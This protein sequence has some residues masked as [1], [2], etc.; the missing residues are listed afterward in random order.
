VKTSK[1]AALLPTDKAWE[2]QQRFVQQLADDVARGTNGPVGSTDL[3]VPIDEPTRQ[4]DVIHDGALVGADGLYPSTMD[5]GA[6]PPVLP[7][8]GRAVVENVVLIN[9]IMTDLAIHRADMQALANTGA[10]VTGVRNATAG[11]ARDL[12]EVLRDKVGQGDTPAVATTARLLALALEDHRPIKIVAHS[13]GALIVTVALEELRDAL[14]QQG[15]TPEAVKAQLSRVSVETFGGAATRYVDGPAYVHVVNALDLVPM[16]TGVGLDRFLPFVHK[17]EGAELRTFVAAHTPK[18]LPPLREG[19]PWV[20]ARAV[21]QSVHGP[22]DV[23]FQQRTK[24]SN[25]D[26]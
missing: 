16:F 21:D 24:K 6:V 19:L 15:H 17:G 25:D 14:L 2:R 9:G 20:F 12:I 13:Q 18:D 22:R 8:N 11:F 26:G 3:V 1:P 5:V 10:A 4:N 23:Y 7:N